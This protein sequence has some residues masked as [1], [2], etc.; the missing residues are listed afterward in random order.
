MVPFPPGG[1]TNI[2]MRIVADKLSE[3]LGQQIV[4]DNRAGAGGTARHPHGRQGRARRLHHRAGYTG[5]LAIAPSLYANL[6][7]DPRKDFAPIGRIATRAELARRAS[8]VSRP[9]RLPS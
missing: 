8:V 9:H 3:L 1:S 7:Y 6:G 5:P 4:I 2:V